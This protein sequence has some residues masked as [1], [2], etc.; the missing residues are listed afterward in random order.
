MD[1]RTLVRRYLDENDISIK[2]ISRHVQCNPE[3]IRKWL[4]GEKGLCD[5]L[6]VKCKEFMDGGWVVTPQEILEKEEEN[7]YNIE[8]K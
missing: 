1:M 3:T 6:M 7:E 8:F 2:K 5:R 4:K